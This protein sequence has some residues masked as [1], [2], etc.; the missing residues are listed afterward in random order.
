VS[1]VHIIPVA[2]GLHQSPATLLAPKGNI[3]VAQAMVNFALKSGTRLPLGVTWSNR[4]DLLKGNE[5][6]GHV[7][8]T[9]DWSSLL[10]SGQAKAANPANE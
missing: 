5:F 2:P 10:L 3:V 9:F 8:F 4:T 1:F 7:G 6:R